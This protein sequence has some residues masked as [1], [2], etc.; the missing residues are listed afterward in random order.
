M[1]CVI[2]I[3]GAVGVAPKAK[4]TL[5]MLNL[6]RANNASVWPET[7]QSK[8]MLKLVE[9]MVAF[10]KIDEASLKELIEKRGK[11]VE[12]KLDVKKIV[13]ELSSGKTANQVGLVNCF[14]LSPPKGGFERKGVKTP[15]TQ[16]GA[17]GDRKN[18]IGKLVMKMI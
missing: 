17:Y 6:R 14:K 18:N 8:R 4:K 15:Y 9:H 12:G 13:E 5:E 10:G 2:R 7:V 16:G 11:V 1:Y 3:R